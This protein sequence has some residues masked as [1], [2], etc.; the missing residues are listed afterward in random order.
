MIVNKIFTVIAEA[1]D[2]M[3]KREATRA[4]YDAASELTETLVHLRERVATLE[5]VQARHDDINDMDGDRLAALETA[6]NDQRAIRDSIRSMLKSLSSRVDSLSQQ[7]DSHDKRMDSLSQRLDLYGTR[8]ASQPSEVTF[9]PIKDQR[10]EWSPPDGAVLAIR[11]ILETLRI[12]HG[13]GVPSEAAREWLMTGVWRR[14]RQRAIFREARRKLIC[15]NELRPQGEG[16]EP[17]IDFALRFVEERWAQMW[18]HIQSQAPSSQ[19]N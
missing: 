12:L 1:F 11:L 6:M 17:L 9:D 7:L 5:T 4:G 8:G 13:G 15:V 10:P 14:P 19:A 3:D 16:T 18:C 2:E